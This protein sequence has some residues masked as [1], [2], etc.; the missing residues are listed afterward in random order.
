MTNSPPVYKIKTVADFLKVPFD[1]REAC[2]AE[3]SVFLESADHLAELFTTGAVTL[4]YQWCDDGIRTT[5]EEGL[6]QMQGQ[7]V[8]IVCKVAD[9]IAEKM[10]G[11]TPHA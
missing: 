7:A 9:Y 3:F 10:S 11:D 2:L 5:A 8:K 1:R 6:E 4:E